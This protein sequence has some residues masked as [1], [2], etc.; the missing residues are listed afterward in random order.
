[1]I[2]GVPP[3]HLLI[4]V[5]KGR[6]V[7][8]QS[9]VCGSGR[10]GSH[11]FQGVGGSRIQIISS[12]LSESFTHSLWSVSAWEKITMFSVWS[13]SPVLNEKCASIIF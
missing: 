12:E 11:F 2:A 7:Q 9:S 4:F 8:G 1:M 3:L 5:G 10:P 6:T 13:L